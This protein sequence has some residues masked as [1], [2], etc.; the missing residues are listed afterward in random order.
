MFASNFSPFSQF[1]SQLF[2]I[3]ILNSFLAA[4]SYF[5]QYVISHLFDVSKFLDNTKH[6]LIPK[7]AYSIWNCVLGKCIV[8]TFKI[9]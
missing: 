1:S 6:F 8:W 9:F 5:P 3:H 2:L 4:R 7:P